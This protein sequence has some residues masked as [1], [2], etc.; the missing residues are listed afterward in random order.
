MDDDPASEYFDHAFGEL[1]QF[2]D[3][4][5]N[6]LTLD[7]LSLAKRRLKSEL[8]RIVKFGETYSPPAFTRKTSVPSLRG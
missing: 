6:W 4:R 7:D 3:C 1:N 2:V 5:E 8:W